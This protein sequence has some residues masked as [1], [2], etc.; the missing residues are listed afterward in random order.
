MTS[1]KPKGKAYSVFSFSSQSTGYSNYGRPAPTI[2]NLN[3]L[4]SAFIM[5]SLAAALVVPPY[6]PF[7]RSSLIT[8]FAFEFSGTLLIRSHLQ[9]NLH[10]LAGFGISCSSDLF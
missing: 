6:S 3:K 9:G 4:D 1:F 10:Y 5:L 2:P 8:C 7:L